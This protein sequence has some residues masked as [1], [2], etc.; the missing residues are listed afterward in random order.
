M[1]NFTPEMIEKA[2]AAKTAEELLALAQENGVEMSEEEAKTCFAQLQPVPGELSDDDLNN[3]AGGGCGGAVAETFKLGDKVKIRSG[4]P[5]KCKVCGSQT[6]SY[7]SYANGNWGVMC[8]RCNDGTLVVL[9]DGS[10]NP[11]GTIEK[12]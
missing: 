9:V 12:I 1:T 3:V 6:G 4:L 7:I 11:A 10:S 5:Y 8:D 2:K